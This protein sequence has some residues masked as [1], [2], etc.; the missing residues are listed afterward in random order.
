MECQPLPI[1]IWGLIFSYIP[2]QR[3]VTLGKLR[4]VCRQFNLALADK[5]KQAMTVRIPLLANLCVRENVE[6]VATACS[7]AGCEHKVHARFVL[8]DF[9]SCGIRFLMYGAKL[10]IIMIRS[11]QLVV[12][13]SGYAE[14][15]T[16]NGFSYYVWG[17]RELGLGICKLLD[18]HDREIASHMVDTI[19]RAAATYC[20]EHKCAN[21]FEETFPADDKK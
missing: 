15:A 21:I 6:A 9:I 5:H 3:V 2:V 7:M 20:S 11:I 12:G 13:P 4:K 18:V 16:G 14:L 10:H 8:R 17:S 1:E 19:R